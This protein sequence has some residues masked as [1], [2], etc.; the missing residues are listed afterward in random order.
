MGTTTLLATC[1]H[2]SEAAVWALAYRLLTA[3][4]ANRSALLY[5]LRAITSYGH[6]NLV[7]EP[8]WQL[9]GA[10]EAL[11]GW[12]PFGLT[13]AFLF[14]MIDKVWLLSGRERPL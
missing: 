11:N 14:G 6:A 9:M 5:S 12:L 4:P 7:L 13:T 8:N 2:G 3:L 1:P 10:I